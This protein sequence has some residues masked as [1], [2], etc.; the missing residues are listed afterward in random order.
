M[1]QS[2]SMTREAGLARGIDGFSLPWLGRGAAGVPRALSTAEQGRQ[3]SGRHS[4][5][6]NET[7]IPGQVGLP[8]HGAENAWALVC[9]A[10]RP[11]R[12]W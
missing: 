9:G 2:L 5:G 3:P 1:H 12:S 7:I 4:E 11:F 6:Y 10:G 8:H